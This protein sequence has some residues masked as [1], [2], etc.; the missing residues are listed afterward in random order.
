MRFIA[1]CSSSLAAALFAIAASAEE[2]RDPA[3]FSL[4]ELMEGMASTSGVIAEFREQ[5]QITLLDKPLESIR[6]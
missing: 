6:A 4:T 2:H 5:K 3:A 1:A